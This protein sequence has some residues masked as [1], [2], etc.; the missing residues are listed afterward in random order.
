MLDLMLILVLIVLSLFYGVQKLVNYTTKNLPPGPKGMPVVGIL[1]EFDILT[2]HLKLY[3]WTTKYGD[4]FQFDLLG[5]TFVSLNS[6]GV[7]REAFNQE[8]NATVTANRPPLF[9]GKYV[10]ENADVVFAQ[11]NAVTRRRKLGYQLLRAYGEGL[12]CRESQIKENIISVKEL[13]RSNEYKN[14]DPSD[15]VE[16]FLQST[17]EV[18]IIGR[19]FGRN[20]KLQKILHRLDD[21]IQLVANPGYDAVYG[22]LPLLRHISL[23]ISRNITEIH[24]TKQQMIEHLEDLSKEDTDNKGIYH[25]L[26]DVMEVRDDDGKQWFT[27]EN[28]RNLLVNFVAAGLLSTRGTIM[29][30]IQLLAKK[31][32]LQI[33]L[34]REVDNVIGSDR[35]PSLADRRSCH[36]TEAFIIESMRYISLVPLAVFHAASED[37]TI[38]GYTIKKNTIIIPNIWTI[39]H[40]EKEFD[41]PFLFKPE[42]FL[43]DKGQLLPSNDPVR[44]RV[45]AFGIGKRSCIG[46]VF[47]RSRMF[48]F[49][50]TL[51]Q[52][53][54]VIEPDGKSLPDLVPTEMLQKTFLQP[55]PFEVRFKL[56]SK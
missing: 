26:K 14:I 12:S 53:A 32:E 8:P 19:S 6:S 27:Q 11:D 30:M 39:H 13:I 4:I 10:L 16:E 28:T 5:K 50:A 2:L 55:Q 45:L 40:S 3:D 52:L 24:K 38:S 23:P 21:L 15:I 20:G 48:L 25:T 22:A 44:K 35:E 54:T 31:P 18:L 41:D 34:Q 56:R 36:L 7:L 47:A 17:V 43:D 9:L 1:F 51:M 33:S 37:V 46:E 29:S 49:I 42:R